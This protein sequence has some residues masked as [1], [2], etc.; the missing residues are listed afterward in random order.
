MKMFPMNEAMLD[1]NATNIDLMQGI[2]K[3]AL[4]DE[5]INGF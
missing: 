2:W 3:F 4:S 5:P 1:S